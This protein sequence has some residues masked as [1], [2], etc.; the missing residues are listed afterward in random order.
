[1]IELQ[2]QEMCTL[3]P[4]NME[5]HRLLK[6]Y[7][8]LGKGLFA[9]THVSWWEGNSSIPKYSLSCG[10]LRMGANSSILRPL[11]RLWAHPTETS[12]VRHGVG[13]RLAPWRD[14]PSLSKAAVGF[15]F[16]GEGLRFLASQ[17]TFQIGF[18]SC[19]APRLSGTASFLASAGM[20]GPI[21]GGG[22]L[23]NAAEPTSK[24]CRFC[25]CPV[26]IHWAS[27]IGGWDVVKGALQSFQTSLETL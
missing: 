27:E 16:V 24:G 15:H 3:P 8:P 4:A 10:I 17:P 9:Q 5:V 11:A 14:A 23:S 18:N 21:C 2:F 25:F 26:E 20:W 7:F 13:L 22:V 12:G 1:M 19:F 6:D